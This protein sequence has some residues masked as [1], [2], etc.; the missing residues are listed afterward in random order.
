MIAIF[1]TVLFFMLKKLKKRSGTDKIVCIAD[2][3]GK[4]L[5]QVQRE[6]LDIPYILFSK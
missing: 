4:P 1:I 6:M 3:F 2:L 5:A